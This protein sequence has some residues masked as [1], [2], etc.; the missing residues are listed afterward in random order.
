MNQDDL[1]RL[2]ELEE[3]K[4]SGDELDTEEREELSNLKLYLCDERKK[5]KGQAVWAKAKKVYAL[6]GTWTQTQT[7]PSG[8]RLTFPTF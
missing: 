6:F 5:S 3:M 4:D 8:W 1:D 7:I 2:A